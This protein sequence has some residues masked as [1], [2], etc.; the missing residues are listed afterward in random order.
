MAIFIHLQS[1][2]KSERNAGI[3]RLRKKGRPIHLIA[4]ELGLSEHIVADVVKDMVNVERRLTFY[5][6][7]E[8]GAR[9]AEDPCEYLRAKHIDERSIA[10][11]LAYWKIG[12]E[13]PLASV[14]QAERD[15]FLAEWLLFKKRTLVRINNRIK[16]GVEAIK[17]REKKPDTCFL[18]GR[19]GVTEKIIP[20]RSRSSITVNHKE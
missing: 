4:L 7:L 20:V 16:E 6:T 11:I 17:Q 14:T 19:E 12:K 13:A 2:K 10:S 9:A 5:E 3:I 15:R 1:L 8:E 18:C